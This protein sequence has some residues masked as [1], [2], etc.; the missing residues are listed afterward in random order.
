MNE[1]ESSLKNSQ[2]NLAKEKGRCLS[3]IGDVLSILPQDSSLYEWTSGFRVSF[4]V[5]ACRIDSILIGRAMV[6]LH[7]NYWK[8]RHQN[9][10]V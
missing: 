8:W 9:H 2:G 10:N 1:Q 5:T 6:E 3:Q 4:H 7:Q